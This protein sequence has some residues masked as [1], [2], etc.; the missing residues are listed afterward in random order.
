MTRA[1]EKA[2]MNIFGEGARRRVRDRLRSWRDLTKKVNRLKHL[3]E[4]DKEDMK[5]LDDQIA[6]SI[7]PRY[8]TLDMPGG[9]GVSDKVGNM[10]VKI[11]TQRDELQLSILHNQFE[12]KDLERQLREIETA[13]D[14]LSAFHAEIVRRYYL[15]HEN[16]EDICCHVHIQKSRFYKALAE[17]LDVLGDQL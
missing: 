13:V 16:W 11:V 8:E 3:I 6:S 5:F 7:I 2:Q 10:A 1:V 14:E 12:L 17:V 15:E 9:S 4:K